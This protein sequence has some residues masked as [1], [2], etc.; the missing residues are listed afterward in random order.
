MANAVPVNS[1]PPVVV[2]QQALDEVAAMR[3]AQ[4]VVAKS[5]D[6]S[7]GQLADAAHKAGKNVISFPNMIR[8]DN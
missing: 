6:E 2:N 1:K 4:V 7:L 8:V 5:H 3:A